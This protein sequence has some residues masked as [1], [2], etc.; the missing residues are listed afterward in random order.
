MPRSVREEVCGKN[1]MHLH[2]FWNVKCDCDGTGS[3]FSTFRDREKVGV[4]LGCISKK[5]TAVNM[6]K[7]VN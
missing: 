2:K 7:D 4:S 1:Q 3:V 6:S 5:F